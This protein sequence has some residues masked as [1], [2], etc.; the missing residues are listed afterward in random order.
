[1]LQLMG[2]KIFTILRS[3]ILFYLNLCK[4]DI[5]VH[6]CLID[7]THLQLVPKFHELVQI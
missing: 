5:V 1:M 3:K 2:K 6:A 7:L 4:Q